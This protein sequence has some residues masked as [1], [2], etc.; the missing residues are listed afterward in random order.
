MAASAMAAAFGRFGLPGPSRTGTIGHNMTLG[1]RDNGRRKLCLCT[2]RVQAAP[3]Q[4]ENKLICCVA[5]S[6]HATHN[7]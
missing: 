6:L 5:G 2:R 1:S 4:A 7:V 3:R